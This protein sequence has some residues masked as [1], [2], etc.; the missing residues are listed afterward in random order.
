MRYSNTISFG[1][2]I[3]L[4][5]LYLMN[6]AFGGPGT[7]LGGYLF[8]IGVVIVIVGMLRSGNE[9]ERINSNG[10]TE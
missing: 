2:L 9:S 1:F 10:E 6:D 7:T 3:C 8:P 5:S 4:I